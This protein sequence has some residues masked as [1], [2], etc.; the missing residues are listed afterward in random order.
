MSSVK[1]NDHFE[2]Q[3]EQVKDFYGVRTDA[4]LA[5][6]MKVDRTAIA[7]WRKR[8][9]I[10]SKYILALFEADRRASLADAVDQLAGQLFLEVYE[11]CRDKVQIGNAEKTRNWWASRMVMLA[12]RLHAKWDKAD[13]AAALNAA[14]QALRKHAFKADPFDFIDRCDE[15]DIPEP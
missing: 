15:A 14:F 12:Y 8:G 6:L 13:D 1:P 10:P 2:R 11:A 7:Q 3:L 5:A 4:E 9:S